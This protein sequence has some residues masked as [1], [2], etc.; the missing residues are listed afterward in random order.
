MAEEE[1]MLYLN[2]GIEWEGQKDTKP[3]TYIERKN[4]R[5]ML[6][7]MFL[8]WGYSLAENLIHLSVKAYVARL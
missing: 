6:K 2:L 1:D 5:R 4:M 8:C 3:E 7:T